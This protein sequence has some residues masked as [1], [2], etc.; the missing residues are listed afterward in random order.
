MNCLRKDHT[1][2][3]QLVKPHEQLYSILTF[4]HLSFLPI[5]INLIQH[6]HFK[7]VLCPISYIFHGISLPFPSV[8]SFERLSNYEQ[9]CVEKIIMQI[10]TM[11]VQRKEEMRKDQEREKSRFTNR[12]LFQ[13]LLFHLFPDSLRRSEYFKVW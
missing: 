3:N 13:F 6:H 5:L 1:L 9:M 4:S 8:L 11:G 2:K 12:Q 7:Q 10:D